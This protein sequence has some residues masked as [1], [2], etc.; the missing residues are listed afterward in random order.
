MKTIHYNTVYPEAKGAIAVIEIDV[1]ILK[2]QLPSF[3]L[4]VILLYII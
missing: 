1:E 2:K 3:L 4:H